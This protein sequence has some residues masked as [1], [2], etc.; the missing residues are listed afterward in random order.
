MEI[1]VLGM[2]FC[3]VVQPLCDGFTS[4]ILSFFEMIKSYFAIKISENNQKIQCNAPSST[5]AIGFQYTE[6]EGDDYYDDDDI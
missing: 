4:L 1:F 6:E 5:H 3:M 2:V